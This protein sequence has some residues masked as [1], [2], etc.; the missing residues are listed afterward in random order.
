MK[1]VSTAEKVTS[2]AI[3]GVASIIVMQTTIAIGESESASEALT[4][5]AIWL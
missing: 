1:N 5:M 3:K 4:A 2:V